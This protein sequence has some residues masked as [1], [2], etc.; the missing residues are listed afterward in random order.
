M[1]AECSVTGGAE[2]SVAGGTEHSVAG[3]AEHSVA[4]G[5][6]C[7]MAGEAAESFVGTFLVGSAY[8]HPNLPHAPPH[9]CKWVNSVPMST[10]IQS[11]WASP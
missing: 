5:T 4:G 2:H 7:S 3:G 9:S 8:C 10:L 1:T 11:A 6:E